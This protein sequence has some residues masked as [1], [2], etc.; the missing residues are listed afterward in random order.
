MQRQRTRTL[1]KNERGSKLSR[2]ARRIDCDTNGQMLPVVCELIASYFVQPKRKS[3]SVAGCMYETPLYQEGSDAICGSSFVE[4]IMRRC[5]QTRLLRPFKLHRY[6][7]VYFR[8]DYATRLITITWALEGV[9]EL[10]RIVGYIYFAEG[11]KGVCIW[12][13]RIAHDQVMRR[14]EC[15]NNI[16]Q[17][18]E[19]DDGIFKTRIVCG[20]IFNKIDWS[21]NEGVCGLC[22]SYIR[23]RTKQIVTFETDKF[24]I[25]VALQ[26]FIRKI[27][28]TNAYESLRLRQLSLL[29]D[30]NCSVVVEGP[31]SHYCHVAKKAHYLASIYFV[32]D[33]ET[34]SVA[35]HCYQESC[36]KNLDGCCATKMDERLQ[37]LLAMYGIDKKASPYRT[38]VY[39]REIF[40]R[41]SVAPKSVIVAC[42]DCCDANDLR[43]VGD[44]TDDRHHNLRILRGLRLVYGVRRFESANVV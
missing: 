1:A 38:G 22:F 15:D 5:D 41:E 16:N 23:F 30:G 6:P 3:H 9:S 40:G 18:Q 37:T 36:Q 31:G 26:T 43:N 11:V 33:R 4:F 39:E 34:Q 35:Q 17:K 42:G 27:A 14:N 7:G 32:V 21:D 13:M 12:K 10:K 44:G 24:G 20:R 19:L 8:I 29:E 25:C 28:R 2:L